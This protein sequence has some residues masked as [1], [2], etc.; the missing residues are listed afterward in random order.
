VL[1]SLLELVYGDLCINH[2]LLSTHFAHL[3]HLRT[4][5]ASLF[6]HVVTFLLDDLN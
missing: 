1:L 2:S 6:T 4:D 5:L 3:D